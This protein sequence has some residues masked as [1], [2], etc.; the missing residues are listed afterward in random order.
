MT[1]IMSQGGIKTSWTL[2]LLF[3]SENS[4]MKNKADLFK[5]LASLVLINRAVLNDVYELFLITL[6]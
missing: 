2:I 4:I 1:E 3:I 5:A 6:F